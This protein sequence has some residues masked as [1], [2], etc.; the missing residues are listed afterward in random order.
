MPAGHAGRTCQPGD[1]GSPPLGAR[2]ALESYLCPPF[3]SHTHG[4]PHLY[5]QIAGCYPEQ[6]CPGPICTS[7]FKPWS[8]V[9]QFRKSRNC[10][11][12]SSQLRSQFRALPQG[13]PRL[14]RTGARLSGSSLCQCGRV[15]PPA[16]KKPGNAGIYQA[17]GGGSGGGGGGGVESRLRARGLHQPTAWLGAQERTCAHKITCVI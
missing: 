12:I 4:M 6:K 16:K 15:Q 14:K 5:P 9:S 8:K 13:Q 17:G 7:L 1:W 2:G 10:V 3:S 11:A